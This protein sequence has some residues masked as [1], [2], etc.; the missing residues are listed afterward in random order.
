MVQGGAHFPLCVRF[1]NVGRRSQAAVDRRN[2]RMKENARGPNQSRERKLGPL[3]SD[4]CKHCNHP[5]HASDDC[6]T[7]KTRGKP[8]EVCETQPGA[9]QWFQKNFM[10]SSYRWGTYVPGNWGTAPAANRTSGDWSFGD[11]GW[12]DWSP[13]PRWE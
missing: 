6:P 1:A 11:G 2:K 8:W 5:S 3:G 4:S 10:D 9:T 12:L 13:P 7:L